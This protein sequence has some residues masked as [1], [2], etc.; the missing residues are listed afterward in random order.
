MNNTFI[1]I[2]VGISIYIIYGKSRQAARPDAK[3][4]QGSAEDFTQQIGTS[5]SQVV[6]DVQNFA[7]VATINPATENSVAGVIRTVQT[8]VTPATPATPVKT[9]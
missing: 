7:A 1:W 8:A 4:V 6:R 5:Y 2:V 3:P 9:N